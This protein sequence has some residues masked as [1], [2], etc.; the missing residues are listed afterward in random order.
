V[1]VG[2]R[3]FAQQKKFINEIVDEEGGGGEKSIE[4]MTKLKVTIFVKMINDFQ[5]GQI[6]IV[7]ALNEQFLLGQTK[8]YRFFVSTID[9]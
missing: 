1:Q 4:K 6:N 7:G 5:K 9:I 8:S 2:T 3:R